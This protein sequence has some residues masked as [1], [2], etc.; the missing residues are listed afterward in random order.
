MSVQIHHFFHQPSSTFT[1]VVYDS[2]TLK[3]MIIDPVLD[4][5]LAS[6]T[7]STNTAET[8]LAFIDSH[9]LDVEWILET[10]AHAD[11]L[12]SA[13]YFKR[14]L[15]AKLA[16]GQNITQVQQHFANTLE[17][18]IKTDG[19][20]Y[21]HLFHDGETF[22]LGQLQVQVMS[23]PGHTSDS[24]CYIVQGNAFVGDTLFMP[25]SG[26][27]R[28]DFPG[29]DANQLYHSICQIFELGDETNLYMCHD[30][31]PNGRELYW[32]TTVSEQ[33]K[34]NIHLKN[35]TTAHDFVQIRRTRDAGLAVPKLLYPSIQVNINAGLIPLKDS[36]NSFI[37]IPLTHDVIFSPPQKSA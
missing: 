2:V 19:S 30:Y 21:D 33:K 13:Q 6:G 24:V 4:F 35:H 31:Q 32:K 25:D 7:L 16:M 28:C 5:D 18:N 12:T 15:G 8:I 26:T 37:K 36:Q 1:Y 14:Q 23:T 3:A 10:H 34:Y 20:Q 27:A 9:H 11:H 22:K 29:G 17:L